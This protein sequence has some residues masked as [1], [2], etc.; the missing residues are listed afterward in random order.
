MSK[1]KLI[2]SKILILFILTLSVNSNVF[3]FDLKKI[4]E[5]LNQ[6]KEQ[7]NSGDNSN[8]LG[9]LMKN[10]QGVAKEISSS[11]GTEQNNISNLNNKTSSKSSGG[12]RDVKTICG[13]RLRFY[14]DLP[15][16]NIAN[17][18]KDF[19]KKSNVIEDIINSTPLI[20]NDKIVSSLG[21]YKGA[22]ESSQ[23]EDI[24][25]KFLLNRNLNTLSIL[26]ETAHISPG[27]SKG[28][29]QIKAD[30]MF[31]YGLIH[32]VYGNSGAN[33]NLGIRYIKE[34]SGI[35]DNIGA[36]TTYGAWQFYGINVPQN[37][38]NGNKMAL[39]GYNRAYEKKLVIG[40]PHS[41]LF[42]KEPFDYAETIFLAMA[43]DTRNP[44]RNQYQSQL[45][46]A[47]QIKKD[48]KKEFAK[49]SYY[50]PQINLT[51]I[52]VGQ[53]NTQ[54]ELLK[55]LSTLAG[56]AE[57]LSK[58]KQQYVLLESKVTG[59][60]E[61]LTE[62]IGINDRMSN[63]IVNVL[64]TKKEIDN[65]GKTKIVNL[66]HDNQVMIYR[67]DELVGISAYIM[68]QAYTSGGAGFLGDSKFHKDLNIIANF[69]KIACKVDTGISEY[70]TKTNVNVGK[71]V[72]S[73]K[74]KMRTLKSFGRNK[75]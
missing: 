43:N 52:L 41:Q 22:F 18:E 59:N 16:P 49:N 8:P 56:V 70:A 73:S 54:H 5:S 6:L 50:S 21:S 14:K 63:R 55:E 36:L 64:R 11:L 28:K 26:R 25:N 4:Q 53:A 75:G 24:F 51:N 58:L 30:A 46:Q 23:I 31:A 9:N 66:K 57:E 35:P 17:L 38:Q 13:F 3:G 39:D 10:M 65:A 47:R 44:F 7:Q 1:F 12:L 37:I 74:T 27:F 20:G 32:Y 29:K 60:P 67:N 34:A 68:F 42:N 61:V 71:P 62:M 45:A 19:G 33:K 2:I 40:N 72:T 48:L 15:A 69:A